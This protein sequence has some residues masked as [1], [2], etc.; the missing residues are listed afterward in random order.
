M[1]WMN[2]WII[3]VKTNLNKSY[4]IDNGKF[5]LIRVFVVVVC[6]TILKNE[7]KEAN[8]QNQKR[9]KQTKNNL[10]IEWSN[11]KKKLVLLL[12]QLLIVDCH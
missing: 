8:K 9:N 1:F 4:N 12:I 2:D 5:L 6:E 7:Y 10:R 11:A 3:K